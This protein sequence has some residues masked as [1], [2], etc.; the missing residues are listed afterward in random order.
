MA[1]AE[2]DKKQSI[3]RIPPAI[4]VFFASTRLAFY[5]IL[6][7]A[8]LS[9]IAVLLPQVPPDLVSGSPEFADWLR[10]AA[11]P[12]TGAWTGVLAYLQIFDVVHS[13]WFAATG[14]MLI[15]NILFCTTRRWPRVLK[16]IRNEAELRDDDYYAGLPVRTELKVPGLSPGDVLPGTISVLKRH[17][18]QVTTVRTEAVINVRAVKNRLSPLGTTLS[19][20]SLI[21]LVMGFM[22][23]SIWGFENAAFIVSEGDNRDVGYGTGLSLF[24]DSFTAEYWENGSPKDYRS[25]VSVYRDGQAVKRATIRVNGPLFYDGVSFYQS[26]FGNSAVMVVKN[27]TGK[28]IYRGS[29]ALAEMV[30]TGGI[31]RPLGSLKLP[32]NDLN[33]YFIAPAT[34]VSDPVLKAGQ[35]G[36][37]VYRG[38]AVGPAASGLLERGMPL[39]LAGLEYTFVSPGQFSGFIVKRDPGTWLVW[40]ASALFILGISLV[41]Y[42]PRREV[43]VLVKG[44]PEGSLLTLGASANRLNS[45]G[46]I[47]TLVR[48]IKGSLTNQN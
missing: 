21:L 33:V 6:S 28:E 40:L 31:P 1:I 46:A 26:F 41:F 37:E 12:V 25:V 48:E 10:Q 4:K 32:G 11:Y 39:E 18:Y 2:S 14:V 27:G 15:L 35:M 30:T 17:H 43:L 20:L 16:S 29:V 9:L 45:P 47:L 36:I 13:I 42:I 23:G 3:I 22:V 8:G 24:L 5:L 19:H 34:T 7:L 44:G 38:D